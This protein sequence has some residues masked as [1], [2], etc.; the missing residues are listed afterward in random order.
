MKISRNIPGLERKMNRNAMA[1]E[2]TPHSHL[3]IYRSA[4]LV[5]LIWCSTF[6]FAQ[7]SSEPAKPAK[8]SQI[9]ASH[10]LGFE[11]ASHNAKGKLSIQDNGLQFQP[12]GGAASMQILI[13]S[14]QDIVLGEQDKEVGGVPMTLGKAAVP[15]AGG[16][17]I[18]LFAHKKY[19]TVTLEYVDTNGGFHGAI[20]QLIKGRGQLLMDQLVA[21]GAHVA[22]VPPQPVAT[23][24]PE[25]KNESK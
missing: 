3:L 18:S 7:N 17:V 14:I 13:A 10:V 1:L 24:A 21:K 20:F 25:A 23:T 5:L 11:S 12:G 9:P 19:D 6:M 2:H 4:C 22:P 16:R 8:D 15:Y